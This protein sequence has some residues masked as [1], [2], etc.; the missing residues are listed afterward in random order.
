MFLQL[1]QRFADGNAAD[2]KLTGDLAFIQPIPRTVMA[3]DN[4][5]PQAVENMRFQGRG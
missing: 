5:I 1:Q 3:G 2:T 4:G